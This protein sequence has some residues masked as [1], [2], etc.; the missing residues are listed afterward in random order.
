MPILRNVNEWLSSLHLVP[1]HQAST[2]S[3]LVSAFKA[4]DQSYGEREALVWADNF[5][6]PDGLINGYMSNFVKLS[7]DIQALAKSM[8]ETLSPSRISVMS[9]LQNTSMSNPDRDK[10]VELVGGMRLLPSPDFRPS[11]VRLKDGS[12]KPLSISNTDRR[13]SPAVNRMLYED[14]VEVGL[15]FILPLEVVLEHVPLFH[16]SRLSWT[17]KSGKK[18]GRPILDCSAGESPLNSTY[19]KERCDQVW[20]RIE[21]P[22]I[23]SLVRMIVSFVTSR[24]VSLGKVI[25]WKVDLKGAYTLLSFHDEDVP[26]LGSLMDENRVIFFLCGVFGWSGTPAAFQVVT[27]A[28]KF[29]VNQLIDGCVDM[30]VDDMLGVSMRAAVE[31]DVELATRVCKRLF[32]SE[33][34]ADLKTEIGCDVDV[35]GYRINLSSECVTITERNYH[36]VIHGLCAVVR[37]MKVSV[38]LMQKFASW[39]RY[40]TNIKTFSENFE[41]IG[42]K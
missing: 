42:R 14:F 8:K 31:K 3:T 4:N 24:G 16:L 28:I 15:A 41:P 11:S 34:I 36:K 5:T 25:L 38:K 17:A 27:R 32:N 37:G 10:L 26:L 12:R 20:G 33:C 21:H 13:L 18:K 39:I 6:F 29:E 23:K 9:V 1:T 2:I 7:Y 40:H 22:T 35:I 30:Y 19:T